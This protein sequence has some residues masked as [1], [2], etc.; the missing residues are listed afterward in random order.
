MNFVTPAKAGVFVHY[1]WKI[2]AFAGMTASGC[3]APVFVFIRGQKNHS[4]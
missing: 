3:Y 1:G 2:P 4:P